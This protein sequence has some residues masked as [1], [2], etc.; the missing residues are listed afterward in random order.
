[1]RKFVAIQRLTSNNIENQHQM[2]KEM[3]KI[4][5]INTIKREKQTKEN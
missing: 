5:L 1:M 3:T 2:S 4:I